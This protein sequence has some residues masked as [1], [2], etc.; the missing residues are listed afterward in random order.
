MRL[1]TIVFKFDEESALFPVKNGAAMK[2]NALKAAQQKINSKII[3]RFAVIN[4]VDDDY[5]W[6]IIDA[7]I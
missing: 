4:D 7:S 2:T 3:A 1:S 6:S 5:C